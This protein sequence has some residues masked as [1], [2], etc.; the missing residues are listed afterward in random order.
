MSDAKPHPP[1]R[2]GAGTLLAALALAAGLLAAPP[3]NAGPGREDNR[4]ALAA[5]EGGRILP[6]ATLIAQVEAVIPGRLL[7]AELEDEDGAPVYELRWQLADGRR[8]ELEIDARDGR[9]RKL[10]G[11][12]LETVFRGRAV[13]PAGGPR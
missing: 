13:S 1:L 8:L 2:R 11:P 7:E 12:R 10:E 5:R 6:L 4:R 3:L 9:W